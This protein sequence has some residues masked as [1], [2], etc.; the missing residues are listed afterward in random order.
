MEL[1]VLK[2]LG[3]TDGEVRVYLALLELGSSTAGRIIEKSKISPSKIYDVLNRLIA[4]GIA[5][6]IMEGKIKN[7]MAAPPKNILN[8][9]ERKENDL[10]QHKTE[11]K[12]II[13][14]LESK[15]KLDKKNF[16]AQIFEGISG[17][18]TVFDMSF[19][20]SKK[21]DTV[22]AFGYPPY[23]SRLFD[24]YWRGYYSRCDKKGVMRKI[25]YNYETWFLKKRSG[26]EL[27]FNRHLPNGISTPSLVLIF[28]DKVATVII[29]EEQKVCFLIQNKEV[30]YSY[31]QYFNFLWKNA[32]KP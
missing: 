23:A 7:F 18:I 21:G 15:Q 32:I 11:F 31:I 2:D 30:A 5:S 13:P 20:E 16:N 3:L 27:T 26:R 4:K 25:I 14:I 28:N 9:I 8:Y 17:L 1:N 19:E 29:T 10:A 24:K 22:Y 12:K 6:Y